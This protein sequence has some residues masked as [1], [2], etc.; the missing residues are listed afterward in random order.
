MSNIC[1]SEINMANSNCQKAYN[2]GLTIVKDAEA[3]HG[4]F[5]IELHGGPATSEY[6]PAISTWY[7]SIK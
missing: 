5:L 6:T 3:K 1:V 4:Q 7:K 2:G